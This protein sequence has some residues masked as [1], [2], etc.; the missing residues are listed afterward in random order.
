MPL[1]RAQRRTGRD[2]ENEALVARWTA[3]WLANDLS[4]SLLAGL[5]ANALLGWWWADP[6]A[7]LVVAGFAAWSGLSAWRE[8]AD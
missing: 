1:A 6:A 2:L 7:A 8:A 4:V 3:T 5:A